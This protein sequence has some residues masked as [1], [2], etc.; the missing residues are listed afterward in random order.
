MITIFT[1][2]AGPGVIAVGRHVREGG[3]GSGDERRYTRGCL[4]RHR[5]R[6]AIADLSSC[7]RSRRDRWLVCH[8]TRQAI[9]DRDAWPSVAP[10][11]RRAGPARCEV[12]SSPG[13]AGRDRHRGRRAAAGCRWVVASHRRGSLRGARRHRAEGG[14]RRSGDRCAGVRRRQ[15][16]LPRRGRD[17][18]GRRDHAPRAHA[19][20]SAARRD[21]ARGQRPEDHVARRSRRAGGARRSDRRAGRQPG[22]RHRRGGDRAVRVPRTDGAGWRTRR[23]RAE[24]PAARRVQV[25]RETR[26]GALQ[27]AA[28]HE[29]GRDDPGDRVALC[30]VGRRQLA[31]LPRQIRVRAV[32]PRA[33]APVGSRREDPRPGERVEDRRHRTRRGEQGRSRE[34][35]RVPPGRHARDAEGVSRAAP[36]GARAPHA[37]PHQGVEPA[38]GR[39][40]GRCS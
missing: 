17:P 35:E 30:G 27:G 29:A 22:R 33:G 13:G 39:R 4:V 28:G 20:R 10:Q 2:S 7:G 38:D 8:R 23:P 32:H 24:E 31:S 16:R 11:F 18:G 9:A 25:F 3:A 37:P 12:R 14:R 5:T 19:R 40:S 1:R 34:G 36:R 21:R 6:Q 15:S 26:Q